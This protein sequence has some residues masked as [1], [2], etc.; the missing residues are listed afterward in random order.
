M[1]KKYSVV[2]IDGTSFEISASG[3]SVG[4]TVMTFNN[5]NGHTV[6]AVPIASLLA[7]GEVTAITGR[8][9]GADGAR[10]PA[11]HVRKI[12]AAQ[13]LDDDLSAR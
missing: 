1:A 12:N 3:I 5:D 2:L 8:I 9:G 11:P 10:P 6:A 4:S 13:P 7:T